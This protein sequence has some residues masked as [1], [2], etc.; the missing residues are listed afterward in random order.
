MRGDRSPLCFPP[1]V[2]R[3][4][5]LLAVVLCACPPG[6]TP[7][8]A[9]PEDS[10]VVVTSCDS[11]DDCRAAG[12]SAACRQGECAPDVP[13]GDDLECG[14][15]ERCVQ[16][17][18][19]FT[20]CTTDAEC[21]TGKCLADTFTCVECGDDTA[22]PAERPVCNTASNTCV[23]CRA[24]DDC[25][26]PGPS[27]CSSSGA[28]VY[29]TS[30]D[31]CPNGLVCSSTNVC[32]GAGEA[33]RC[34]EG[35]A[36][37][38]GLACVT[39]GTNNVCLRS[40][41]LYTPMCPV[42]GQICYRLTYANSNSLVFEADGPI[43]VCFGAQAGLRGLREPC[44][45]QN[46][47]SNCQPNL[48]CV[49]ETAQLALC[50]AYCNPSV[51]GSCPAGEVCRAFPG[52]YAGRPYGLCLPDTGFGEAC[53]NDG[54]CRAGLSCQPYD[55]PSASYDV[56]PF[57]Q[58]NVGARPGL[59][60]CGDVPQPDGGVLLADRTCQSGR[61][62]ADP[63]FSASTAPGYYCLAAC[64]TNGDCATDAGSGVCDADFDVTTPFDTTGLMRGCRPSCT[65]EADCAGYDAGVT[66]RIRVVSSLSAPTYAST[67]SPPGPGALP[68]GSPCTSGLQCESAHCFLDDARGVRRS[69]TCVATCRAGDTC[70]TGSSGLPLACQPTALLLTR[71]YDG[72]PGTADD[73]YATPT[74][75][76][77][78]P[79]VTDADCGGQ[80]CAVEVDATASPPG[81]ALARRC[82][83]PT[84]GIKRG[85]EACTGD[86]ECRSGVCGE[87]QPPSTGA[88]R[89]CFEACDGM[90]PCPGTTTC[91]AGALRVDT[92]AGSFSFDSCAP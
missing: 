35:I 4:L 30:N 80:V 12:L 92:W 24:D 38:P 88:G 5:P 57:C 47:G 75:C 71:G 14:L 33:S 23:A 76:S 69:G 82:R 40:C 77:G 1:A 49:P 20:G 41:N 42:M 36:C 32:A 9:G 73:A 15:G 6:E 21:D 25:P 84:T 16:G 51:S 90:T 39:V 22:C 64:K 17:Q 18:C 34:P 87:L 85:G 53:T 19:R 68:A 37:A 78:A 10:G 2:R 43:G 63:L 31:H 66:C 29:C 8:D 56:S 55:D 48:Q 13:C 44:L 58:F 89:A 72:R 7:V 79:C 81:T 3:L 70:A 86:L 26:R 45:R 60:P 83:M 11:P 74:L 50:R 62:V 65:S 54:Q 27:H 52:D 59:A 46:G 61:C 91:R 67:C 28:C